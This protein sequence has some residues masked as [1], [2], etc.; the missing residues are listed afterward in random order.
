M[1]SLFISEHELSLFKKYSNSQPLVR[2]YWALLNRVQKNVAHPGL[3]D[4]NSSQTWWHV[5]S[6]LLT[7]AAMV[8]VIKPETAT[9]IWLRDVTLS[10]I[11][12]PK[13]DWVGPAFRDHAKNP[14]VGHLETA[15]LSW[16]TAIVLDLAESIFTE[17]EQAEITAV[18]RERAI[19]FCLR[20]VDQCTHLNNWRCVMTAGYA[21]PAAVLNDKTLLERAARDYQINCQAFQPDGS[22]AESLQY[23]NYAALTLMFTYEALVRR[24]SAWADQLNIDAYAPLVKWAA[25]SHFYNKPLSGWGAMPRPRAANFNDSAA[26]FRPSADLLLHI[27]ARSKERDPK[28]AGIA[29]WLFDTLYI[30]YVSQSPCDMTSFGFYNTFG[31]LTPVLLPQAA[32]AISPQN[33]DLP[34]TGAFS[35]GDMFTRDTWDGRTILAVHTSGDA[36]CASAHQHRDLNSFILVHNQERMLVD[37]GHSCYRGLIHATEIGTQT[38]NTCTFR[39]KLPDGSSRQLEQMIPGSRTI[40]Q[41]KPL[42]PVPRP[43]K[44]L[45]CEAIDDISV[46]AADAATSYGAPVEQFSRFWISIGAH[47]LFI[48]DF[49]N[50]S[51]PVC[52]TWHWLLNNR[53]GN[54]DLKLL[55]GR[56]VARRGDAGMKL[57]H[58][59][60]G[61][62]QGPQYAFVHDCYHPLPAQNGE[63]RQGSGILLQ[64]E[65]SKYA[66]QRSSVHAI[67]LDDYGMISGWHLKKE[68]G[69]FYIENPAH[70]RLW[71]L[72]INEETQMMTLHERHSKKTYQIIK[73]ADHTWQLRNNAGKIGS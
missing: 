9:G 2:F 43:G 16:A 54:L 32:A 61:N 57:F 52:T 13:S 60:G 56:I 11:R 65:E 7:D 21:V 20:W 8:Y 47:I 34:R 44:K 12:R 1:Q 73:S 39:V 55:G 27:S 46:I 51:E 28:T 67:A 18:L 31:F 5:A 29:R 30:P 36:Q 25:Y 42:E 23:A 37:P 4:Q 40:Y 64:W 48:V 33:A 58:F 59:A 38:H 26:T 72:S 14:P 66:S 63:G 71:Q 24:D 68:N 35:C 49:I 62:L 22:Y 53:D 45:L 15:H 3:L 17:I 19:P 10:I 70:D 50:A 41:Q 69:A 6:E